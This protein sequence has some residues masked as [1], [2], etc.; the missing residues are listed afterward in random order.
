MHS[1][2]AHKQGV[3]LAHPRAAKPKNIFKPPIDDS[4]Q[5]FRYIAGLS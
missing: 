3:G 2:L 4:F 5:A 1:I